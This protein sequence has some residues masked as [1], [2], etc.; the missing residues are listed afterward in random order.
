MY[1]NYMAKPY[2]DNVRA[3]MAP[4]IDNALRWQESIEQMAAD[5][6]DTFIEVGVGNTLKKLISRILPESKVY[7][8]S[9]MEEVQKIKEED[10]ICSKE[11]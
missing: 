5:G 6:F 4:Q 10:F 11:K 2:E 1:S 8:V 9:S 7:S 3:W